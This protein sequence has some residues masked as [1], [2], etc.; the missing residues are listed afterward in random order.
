MLKVASVVFPWLATLGGSRNSSGLFHLGSS[1][2]FLGSL[3]L[4][5][6]GA[7]GSRGV[8]FDDFFPDFLLDTLGQSGGG[9]LRVLGG[10]ERGLESFSEDLLE[11]VTVSLEPV[12]WW[13][14]SRV[15]LGACDHGSVT[16][17]G[18]LGVFTDV[19]FVSAWL[20]DVVSP[21]VE[22]CKTWLQAHDEV[23]DVLERLGDIDHDGGLLAWFVGL[24][25]VDL[26][27]PDVGVAQVVVASTLSSL[28][29]A[30]GDGLLAGS[31]FLA[32]VV[33]FTVV[34]GVVLLGSAEEVCRVVE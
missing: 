8:D 16:S 12:W 26:D 2:C 34:V 32:L 23:E 1:G 6:L 10:S 30:G 21:S 5:L 14:D 28:V 25:T 22:S 33:V 13:Q 24:G 31:G 27:L 15:G 18:W 7:V 4:S 19:D 3:L 11:L 17:S 29:G 9:L 20:D